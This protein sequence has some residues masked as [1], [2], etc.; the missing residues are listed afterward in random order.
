MSTDS[1]R[2][3]F[4]ASAMVAISVLSVLVPLAGGAEFRRLPV[5]VFRD[6]M[7]SAWVEGTPETKRSNHG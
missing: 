1:P 5:S 7:A 6:K 2:L 3:R 4:V